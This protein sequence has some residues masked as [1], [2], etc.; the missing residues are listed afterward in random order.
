MAYSFSNTPLYV[1]EGDYVQFRF[2]APPQWDF[3]QTVTIQLGDLVQYW[4]ITTI[5][6]DFTPDPYPFQRVENAE[7]DT[8][9]TYA[10]GSRTGEQIVTVT[11]LTQTTQ[12]PVSLGANV[13]GGTDV[14]AMRIDYNGDGTWDTDWIQGNGT[15]VVENGAKIQIRGK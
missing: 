11:G 3:T 13:A 15:E 6:E 2:K 8:L 1:S 10:D 5:P 4:L 7:L 9:Y 14:Y 12:A